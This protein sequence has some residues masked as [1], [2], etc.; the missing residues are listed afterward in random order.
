M[1][2]ITKILIWIFG[3]ITSY[4]ILASVITGGAYFL[5]L[6]I[7]TNSIGNYLSSCSILASCGILASIIFIWVAIFKYHS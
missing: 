7:G 3:F 4:Y 2:G 6:L 1:K 5:S